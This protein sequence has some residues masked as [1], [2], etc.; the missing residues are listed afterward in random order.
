MR[1]VAHSRL[2]FVSGLESGS[3]EWGVE[4]DVKSGVELSSDSSSE[5]C[6]D[7][8]DDIDNSDPVLP[9][10]CGTGSVGRVGSRALASRMILPAE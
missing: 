2:R 10:M 9:R 3:L 8:T 4:S 1:A 6:D 7:A 5:S